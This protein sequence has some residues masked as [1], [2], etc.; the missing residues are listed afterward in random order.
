MMVRC[1]NTEHCLNMNELRSFTILYCVSP[2]VDHE[3]KPGAGTYTGLVQFDLSN[4]RGGNLKLNLQVMIVILFLK[5]L[6][7]A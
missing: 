3:A 2:G 5:Q 1:F 7:Y 4:S 6:L